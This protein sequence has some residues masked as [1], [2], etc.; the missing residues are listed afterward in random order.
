M[1]VLRTS[2]LLAGLTALFLAL[3]YVIGGQSGMVIALVVAIATNAF[4][5]WNSD[6]MVLRMY[7]AQEVDARSAPE[8]VGW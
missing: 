5:Y 1:S 6:T 3:G 4:A 8:L 7:D 2:L